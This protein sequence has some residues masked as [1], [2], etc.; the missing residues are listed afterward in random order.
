MSKI[1]NCLAMVMAIVLIGVTPS[2]NVQAS[3]NAPYG[4]QWIDSQA[5]LQHVQYYEYDA[6]AN[7]YKISD[8]VAINGKSMYD[9]AG[10]LVMADVKAFEK[11]SQLLR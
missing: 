5:K 11:N 2:M 9:I 8:R 4:F 3:T 6:K 1:K 7:S 10:L